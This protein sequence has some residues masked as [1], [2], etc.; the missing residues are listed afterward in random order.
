MR[1]ADDKHSVDSLNLHRL[2]I[3]VQLKGCAS[4]RSVTLDQ[5]VGHDVDTRIGQGG[6][7][8]LGRCVDGVGR[9]NGQGASGRQIVLDPLSDE[10]ADDALACS[11]NRR[12]GGDRT[13]DSFLDQVC[14]GD[15]DR[16]LLV[17]ATRPLPGESLR[18]QQRSRCPLW[19]RGMPPAPRWNRPG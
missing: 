9:P 5:K 17:G 2:D 18:A 15:G 1:A 19:V 11:T 14:V 4:Q 13:V 8:D 7:C 10:R 12:V 6:N 3:V 16:V